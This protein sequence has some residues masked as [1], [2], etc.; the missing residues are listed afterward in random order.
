V[1]RGSG[2]KKALLSLALSALIAGVA[3]AQTDY[4]NRAF[5]VT[6]WY[7]VCTQSAVPKPILDKLHATLVKT[8][9]MPEMMARL[10]DST[11]DVSPTTQEEFAAFIRAEID[12][13]AAVVRDANVPKQ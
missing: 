12:K 1:P 2:D 10:A 8:L 4:P 5:E 9:N 3:Q 13:W 11:I 6:V 7:G